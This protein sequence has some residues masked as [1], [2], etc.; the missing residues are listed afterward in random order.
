M[1]PFTTDTITIVSAPLTAG[2]ANNYT[3][4]WASAS[5]TTVRGLVQQTGTTE[6]TQANDQ[7]AATFLVLLPPGATIGSGDRIEW[8]AGPGRTLE[9]AGVPSSWP[10]PAAH[11]EA[12]ATEVRG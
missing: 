9:V 4:D 3:R 12:T 6:T 1:L 10:G 8:S 11:V 7:V 2:Y 5:R